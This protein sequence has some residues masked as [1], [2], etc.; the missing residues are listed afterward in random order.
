MVA[1][2]D[3]FTASEENNMI[4]FA[5]QIPLGYCKEGKG[6]RVLTQQILFDMEYLIHLL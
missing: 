6:L 5:I 1:G 4:I 2:V 3:V